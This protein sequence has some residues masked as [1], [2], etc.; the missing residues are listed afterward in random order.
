MSTL[1]TASAVA[2]ILSLANAAPMAATQSTPTEIGIKVQLAGFDAA[3]VLTAVLDQTTVARIQQIKE[4]E[5]NEVGPWCAGF[6]DA[7]ATSV[8]RAVN[9]DG[10][11]DSANPAIYI[12]DQD[13]EKTVTVA[14]YW[15]AQTRK[16][17]ENFVA[18]AG[19]K[20]TATYA[21][22]TY[23]TPAASA[24]PPPPVNNGGNNGNN[25]GAATVRVQIETE[26]A[27]TFFQEDL[28]ANA[29]IVSASA[30]RQFADQVFSVNVVGSGDCQFF[31]DAAG[32][33]PVV[34][35]GVVAA[36][37]CTA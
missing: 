14:S 1:S 33:T 21:T 3:S 13:Q 23:S 17:V 16:E 6:S 30:V 34:F 12:Q 4:A 26:A 10:I 2:A 32:Q 37:E 35:P 24:T 28:A 19:Q 18:R 25:N 20:E 15:C 22:S 11:F 5:V 36:F 8:V 9:G 7:A 27:T 31:A 29:G